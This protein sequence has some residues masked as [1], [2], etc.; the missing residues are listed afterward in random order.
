MY[1]L[2]HL[3]EKNWSMKSNSLGSTNLK[4]FIASFLALCLTDHLVSD[5]HL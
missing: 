5:E 3:K 2:K 1:I 4:G